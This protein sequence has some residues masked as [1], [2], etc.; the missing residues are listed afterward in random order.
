MDLKEWMTSVTVAWTCPRCG[1]AL[2]NE[3]IT[4]YPP[5]DVWRCHKCGWLRERKN[6]LVFLPF[7]EEADEQ[8]TPI[9]PTTEKS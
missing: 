4:T 3:V 2:V 5:I 9:F 8:P 6:K 7:P 1:T